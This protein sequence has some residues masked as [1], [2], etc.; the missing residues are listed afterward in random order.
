[1]RIKHQEMSIET[2]S[3]S[4][5]LKVD[6]PS[7]RERVEEEVQTKETMEEVTEKT[8]NWTD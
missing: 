2:A 8:T 7:K 4:S 3:S 6:M 5:K 1:M